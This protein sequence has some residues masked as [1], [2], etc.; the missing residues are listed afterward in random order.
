MKVRPE[1]ILGACLGKCVH[2]AGIYRFLTLAAAQGYRS[3]FL[4]PA[5]DGQRLLEAIRQEDPDIVAL[6]Y[7]LSP[8]PA[9]ELL[10]SLRQALSEAG[11]DNRRF[12]FGGTPPVAEVARQA[13]WFE[14]VFDGTEGDPAVIA[15]LRGQG[16]GE[17]EERY[18][19][20]LVERI[21]AQFPYPLIR[22]HFG[23]PSLEETVEGIA[24]LAEERA[25][26]IISLAPDQNAQECFFRPAEMDPRQDGSGGVPVRSAEDFRALYRASRRGNYP[27][28]RCYS[29]TRDVIPMARLL[30]E[31]INLAWGAVP[32]MW[33][34]VLDGRSRRP[35]EESIREAQSA[36]AWHAAEGIPLE[37][38]EAHHW[39]LRDAH[40]V[41]TVAAAFLAAYNARAAG[42][43]D[44]LNQFMFNTPPGLSF[45]MDLAKMLAQA[46][47]VD[48]LATESFRVWRQTRTGLASLPSDLDQAK[49]QLAASTFLQ[50]ALR[51]HIVH[52]V[53]HCEAHH[54][55]T[56]EDIV[57][58][59][60]I[61]RG[62]I[63]NGLYGLPEVTLDPIVQERKEELLAEAR[64]LLEAIRDLAPPG[65]ADPWT[66]PATL[67]RAVETGLLDA[68]HLV[69][70]PV[71]RG[72]LATRIIGGACLAVDPV[73]AAPLSEKQRVARLL[74][75]LQAAAG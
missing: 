22:H 28:L 53:S 58:A 49:G 75:R 11:L 42:V 39:G 6:S 50:M 18:P 54:A 25:V 44:Y 51:P 65:V 43:K 10:A 60:K 56:P 64:V 24:R 29:G 21:L 62:V 16:R 45:Q 69:G 61:V 73:T 74:A 23:L 66:D 72:E 37:V 17:M 26:D 35:L 1:K 13:G 32:L 30:K 4:G 68:P 12:I 52:V 15:Y 38:N 46:E 40:D 70:N 14:A 8:Q 34:N 48:S 41:I 33:Y 3:C 27:L 31:T 5:V 20:T 7:R 67:T 71:A 59:V 36:M 57:E 9:R 47:I 19:Q 55:A 63:R 2:V